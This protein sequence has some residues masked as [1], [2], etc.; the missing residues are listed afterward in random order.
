MQKAHLPNRKSERSTAMKR[1]SSLYIGVFL[2]VVTSPIAL[3]AQ[4]ITFAAPRQISTAAPNNYVAR[5]EAAGDFNGD[6]KADLLIGIDE[7][8]GVIP[9]VL[10]GNGTG[11]FSVVSEPAMP[12]YPNFPLVAD[13]NGDG[14]DDVVLLG[15]NQW[16]SCATNLLSVFLSDGDGDFTAGYTST[17]PAG[18]VSGIIGDFN[19]DGKP[20]IA[21]LVTPSSSLPNT[22]PTIVIFL[23]QGDDS[24]AAT[25]YTDV[26]EGY[27]YGPWDLTAGDFTGNGNLD[28][29]VLTYIA[30]TQ[31]GNPSS[32]AK[33]YTFAGT[34]DGS[35]GAPR[36]SYTFDSAFDSATNNLWAADLNGDG[37]TDLVAN[38]FPKAGA[39]SGTP[40]R[41]ATLLATPTGGFE[42]ASAISVFESISP[43][44]FRL[45]DLNG[46][47]NLDYIGLGVGTPNTFDES[48]ALGL[49]YPGVGDGKFGTPHMSFPIPN[50]TNTPCAEGANLIAVPLQ[51]GD[52]PS[53]IISTDVSTLELLVNTTKK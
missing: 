30:P 44:N 4:E 50:C 17:L 25:T 19:N 36:L 34:G 28:L 21:V 13:V 45:S 46:D 3:S 9:E 49:I 48:A 35:F 8:G 22:V 15:C 20:D 40:S 43:P 16:P 38:L 33:L 18:N 41:V 32:G 42:W 24:F 31:N 12:D 37:K 51:R 7:P 53:L 1:S 27:G 10:L 23:N 2:A 39:G 14:K 5:L 52:L 26:P 11:A 6:G 47:G 29:A